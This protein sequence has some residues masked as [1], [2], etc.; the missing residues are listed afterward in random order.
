ML[1]SADAVYLGQCA[2]RRGRGG[3]GGAGAGGAGAGGA[4]AGGAGAGGAG[5]ASDTRHAGEHALH[6]RGMKGEK[7][8]TYIQPVTA[9]GGSSPSE[10]AAA[11]W[12]S[13]AAAASSSDVG[14][15]WQ[16]M[17]STCGKRGV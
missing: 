13:A 17:A 12:S 7:G 4:G 8:L 11:S 3:A 16:I 10:A 9:L 6:P 14:A 5:G 2:V 15:S 1:A